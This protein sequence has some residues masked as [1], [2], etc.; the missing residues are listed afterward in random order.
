MTIV[1]WISVVVFG[2]FFLISLFKLCKSKNADSM[3]ENI[4]GVNSST[5][6]DILY[7]KLSILMIIVGIVSASGCIV[8]SYLD[9]YAV[10]KYNYEEYNAED[11][12]D[13]AQM[14]LDKAEYYANKKNPT[15]RDIN[16]FNHYK[17]MA[18]RYM[19]PG[20]SPMD[21]MDW[22]FHHVFVELESVIPLSVI[23]LL[24]ILFPLYM[25]PTKAARKNTHE[26]TTVIVWLNGILGCTV[27]LWIVLLIWGSSGNGNAKTVVIQQ[28]PIQ[29]TAGNSFEELKKLK[30]MGMITDEEFEEKRKELLKR[31]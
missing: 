31:I 21:Y 2:I 23:A 10:A 9:S 30:D 3:E 13:E 6:T 5:G 19:Y 20:D 1:G 7:K 8:G 15:M 16:S 14:Y 11:R 27:I 28:T 12:L 25:I 4:Y 17:F 24:G 26:Q 18:E 22:R 29:P